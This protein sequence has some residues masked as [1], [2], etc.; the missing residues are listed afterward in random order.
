MI[1]ILSTYFL[2]L[3]CPLV[4][5]Q[6]QSDSIL[7]KPGQGI[8]NILVEYSSQAEIKKY[9]HLK[10]VSEKGTGIAC[11][12]NGSHRFRS[13][14]YKNDSLG[15]MFEFKTYSNELSLK[16]FGNF[17]SFMSIITCCTPLRIERKAF[18][19][20]ALLINQVL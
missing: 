20:F 14:I 7:I 5:G 10:Y 11:G 1:R 6:S 8:D 15:L 2:T 17:F 9:K 19:L 3:L 16:S 12:M 13:V 18:N 4:Y